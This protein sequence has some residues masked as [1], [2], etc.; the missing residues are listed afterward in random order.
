MGLDV[1][2]DFHRLFRSA[3][4]SKPA[5]GAREERNPEHKAYGRDELDAPSCMEGGGASDEGAA[6]AAKKHEKNPEFYGELLYY[7]D[8]T[9]F[10][11]LGD[12]GEVH[13]DLGGSDSYA[14]AVDKTT[15]YQHTVAIAR[16]LNGCPGEPE[17]TRYEDRVAAA[18]FVGERTSEEGA[19]H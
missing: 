17:E 6:V 8:G 4:L 18:D 12:L 9:A 3:N 16:D 15:A 10:L 14:D 19:N 11:F 7:Y 5:W 13:R 2:K 1:G